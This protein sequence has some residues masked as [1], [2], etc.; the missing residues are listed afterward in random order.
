MKS[1][2]LDLPFDTPFGAGEN[3]ALWAPRD[4]WTR[5][6]QRLME[7]LGE[8]RRIEYKKVKKIDFDD[9]ATYFSAFSNTLDGGVII[10]GAHC[11]G[12]ATGCNIAGTNITNRL[13][14][15]HTRMCPQ[16]RPEFK[17][18]PVVVNNQED[19]CL[20]IYIPYI[21]KLVE[22]NKQQAWIRYGDQRHEMS[23]EEKRDFR[24]TRQEL[25]F[26][27]E[28]APYAFPQ[29]FD[30]R[31]IQDYCDSFRERE[32][33]PTWSNED[34]LIDRHLLGSDGTDCFP[35]NS[36]VLLAAKDPCKS[37]P[38]CRVHI[39]RFSS[40]Q[41]GS[42]E[43]YNPIKSKYVEGNIVNII[44]EVSEIIEELNYNVTWLNKDGKFVTTTEYPRWSWF[45]ALIN[46]CVHRSYS[47]SG[48][49]ITVK[50]FSGRLEI[51]SPGGFVPPVRE[52][53]IYHTRS[54]RNYHTMNAL[55]Y[56]GYVLMTREGTKRIRDS[57]VEWGLPEPQFKQE[58]IHGVV[59]RVTLMNDH[60]SRKRS[61][62]RDVAQFFGVD[63]WRSLQEH[64][65]KIIAYAFRNK[66]IQVSEAQRLTGRT[67]ATSKKD[68]EKLARKEVLEFIAGEYP[69]DPKAHYAIRNIFA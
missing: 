5:L 65:I 58:A 28:R 16:A 67:W 54:S 31:I 69:R 42:G 38:G 39:V 51:E 48:T 32:N 29:E 59:V 33:K 27:T 12:T 64:E 1:G 56:L 11:D 52:R 62:D 66:T 63:L 68:L 6:T 50:F 3:P 41:E 4:I 44:K 18:I 20:A 45:E 47:F 55:R 21:G 7:H 25:S 43:N 35:L 49:E 14:N 22:T 19:C 34:V 15:C 10:F 46:A 37:I 13:E 60:E 53:T 9:I 17:R 30:L 24:S 36:L 61:T 26:E 40:D 8:D 57:M 23:D 2:Q